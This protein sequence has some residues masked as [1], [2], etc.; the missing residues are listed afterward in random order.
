[1]RCATSRF[2]LGHMIKLGAHLLPEPVK[3]FTPSALIAHGFGTGLLKPASGTWGSLSCFLLL[4][5]IFPYLT[6]EFR[7]GSAFIAYWIGFWSIQHLIQ[8]SKNG[9]NDPSWVVIDEWVGLMIASLLCS[10]ILDFVV[11]FI[12]FRL[13]DI[14]KPWPISWIDKTVHGAHG[15]M[16]DDVL[17]GIISLAIFGLLSYYGFVL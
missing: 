16:L 7:I 14:W 10:T 15:I 1:M 17:A 5:V 6:L 2:D 9:L 4:I 13:F 11:A 12:L 3:W 8:K